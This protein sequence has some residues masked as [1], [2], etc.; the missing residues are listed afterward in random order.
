ME[1]SDI[2]RRRAIRRPLRRSR[3][4]GGMRGEL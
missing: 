2:E 4:R 3:A 1:K